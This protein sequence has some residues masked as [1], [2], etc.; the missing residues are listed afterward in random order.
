M[1]SA[2]YIVGYVIGALVLFAGI[3]EL[4]LEIKV[5]NS[6]AA[7][8]ESDVDKTNMN[9]WF[10]NSILKIVAGVIIIGVTI[11][12]HRKNASLSKSSSV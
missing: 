2:P 1:S 9:R 5:S 4:V 10:Y 8:S 7:A 3:I 12:L 11:Y 6:P